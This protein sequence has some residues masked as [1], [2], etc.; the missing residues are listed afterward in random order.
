M[1][2]LNV[3]HKDV[4]RRVTEQR[5]AANRTNAAKSTGP[6]TKEGKA[7]AARNAVKHG[8]LCDEVR[9]GEFP[10]EVREVFNV[11]RDM[12]LSRL[13]PEGQVEQLLAERVVAAA[14]RLRRA[15]RMEGLLTANEICSVADDRQIGLMLPGPHNKRDELAQAVSR[16]F[17]RGTYE[18]LSR[19]ETRIERGMY[20]ALHELQRLQGR[21]RGELVPPPLAVDIDV[22]GR[23]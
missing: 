8:L 9:I 1:G 22:S 19:Y 17:H 10:D 15:G 4:Y 23:I 21:R 12:L 14:W 5:V 20:K 16:L 2:K 13:E 6:R 7:I 3:Q 11:F 18:Q